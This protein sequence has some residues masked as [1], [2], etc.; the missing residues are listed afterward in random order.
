MSSSRRE[1][2][3]R[4]TFVALAAGFP[5]ALT[6]KAYGMGTSTSKSAGLSLA[7]FKSQ[8]GTNFLINHE[9]SKVKLKLV[10]VADFASRKQA[11]AGK[12]G[13][14][15]TFRGPRDTPL[16]Q[17]TYLIHHEELGMFSFLVVPV[18]IKDKR[19]PHYEAVINRLHS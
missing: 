8:L 12:E 10:D 19:A 17:D 7:A 5:L 13:F 16:K 4:G 18:G 15:L 2:L 9:T 3:K 14:S 6:E 1:F 11:A